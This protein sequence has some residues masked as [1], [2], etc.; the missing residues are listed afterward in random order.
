MGTAEGSPRNRLSGERLLKPAVHFMADVFAV[1]QTIRHKG[2][3]IAGQKVKV[4]AGAPGNH[5]DHLAVA[6]HVAPMPEHGGP[7]VGVTDQH[8]VRPADGRLFTTSLLP[9]NHGEFLAPP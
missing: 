3:L 2:N 7:R 1:A 9:R 6:A 8:A 5:L 4:A